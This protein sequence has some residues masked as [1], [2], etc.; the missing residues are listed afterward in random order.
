MTKIKICGL[1]RDCDID[2]VNEA[3]PDYAGFVFA[4]SRRQ[5]TKEQAQNFRKNLKPEIISVGVF[6]DADISEI[7]ELFDLKVIS[8]AQ[9]HGNETEEYIKELREKC[10]VKI[11]K[12]V[13]VLKNPDFEKIKNS[14]ADFILF[15]SGTG[16]GKTFSWRLLPEMK[17][18]F[19]LAG[20]LNIENIDE[21]VKQVKPFGVDLSSGVETDGFKDKEK[22]LSIVRRIKNG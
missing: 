9:L 2:F 1:F 12:A 22:I 14:F 6:V 8:A 5:I 21:A 11:I 17:R 4:K 13:N 7:K 16:S 3:M 20:G 10:A 19:F 18:D 15:D